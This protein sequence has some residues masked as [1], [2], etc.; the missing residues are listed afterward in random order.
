MS[1]YLWEPSP[2]HPRFHPSGFRS[3]VARVRPD[4]LYRWLVMALIAGA[5]HVMLR[6]IDNAITIAVEVSQ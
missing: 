4:R 5:A 6:A 2:V 1:L 3:A